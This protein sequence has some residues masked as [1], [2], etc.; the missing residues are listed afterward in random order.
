M[1]IKTNSDNNSYIQNGILIQ[2]KIGRATGLGAY[3][4]LSIT[5]ITVDGGFIDRC[6]YHKA[7]DELYCVISGVIELCVDGVAYPLQAGD[8]ALIEPYEKHFVTGKC[9]KSEAI[10]I[11]TP[12]W[13]EIDSFYC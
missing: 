10:V 9:E 12:A 11:C 4:K 7:S 3:D 2:E 6:H 1:I 13:S 8:C 5:K